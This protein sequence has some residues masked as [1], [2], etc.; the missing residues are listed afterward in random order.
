M[1]LYRPEIPTGILYAP[2]ALAASGTAVVGVLGRAIVLLSASIIASNQVNVKWQTS[3]GPTDLSGYAYIAQYGGYI[4][5]FNAGG[6][7]QTNP[8]DSLL[9]NL[10]SGIP[11]GGMISYLLA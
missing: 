9:L 6:W 7:C 1:N 2:I 4:L 8:G 5:P 10:S 3:T 11:I